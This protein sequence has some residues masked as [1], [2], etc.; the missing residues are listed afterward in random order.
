MTDWKYKIDLLDDAVFEEIENDRNISIPDYLTDFIKTNNA[1]TPSEYRF[2]LNDEEKIFGAVLSYN[3][4]DT[5]TVF[6]ALSV[7][8]NTRLL[9]FAI[10]PFGNYIC[11]DTDGQ[12]VVFW[13]HETSA[14]YST[15]QKFMDFLQ[16]LY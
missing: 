9:P 6:T 10:D 5:D 14:V 4:D 7:I 11:F 2:K 3:K 1:A 13:D 8:E 12:N 15:N 16:E